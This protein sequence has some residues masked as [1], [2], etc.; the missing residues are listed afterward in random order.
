MPRSL[1][2]EPDGVAV[3]L[4]IY[5]FLC[6]AVAAFF[7]LVMYYLMQPTRIPNPGMAAH[8]SSPPTVSYLELLRSEREAAQRTAKFKLEP[9]TTGSVTR[10]A[11]DMNRNRLNPRNVSQSR[12]RPV[13]KNTHQSRTVRRQEPPDTTHYAQRPSFSDYRAMY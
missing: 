5:L 9:E 11:P 12:T 2:R 13:S 10:E 6:C 7:A 8:K 1:Q 4:L 3:S